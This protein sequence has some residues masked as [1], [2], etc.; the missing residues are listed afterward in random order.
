MPAGM[1]RKEKST[2]LGVV[3]WEAMEPM[4]SLP[5]PASMPSWCAMYADVARAA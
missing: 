5:L 1:K 3:R 4:A 2:P